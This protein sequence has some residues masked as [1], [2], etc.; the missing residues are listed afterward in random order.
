MNGKLTY[1]L[2]I[3]V[4]ADELK[5]KLWEV[6]VI[7]NPRGF[8]FCLTSFHT[9]EVIDNFFYDLKNIITKL[10]ESNETKNIKYSPCIY[11]TMEKIDDND[12]MNDVITDYLHVVNG[13]NL[14]L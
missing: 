6:N 4:I 12:I 1:K 8:H 7:Q 10:N 14:N 2:N 9:K 3:N 11:G 5:S 13:A